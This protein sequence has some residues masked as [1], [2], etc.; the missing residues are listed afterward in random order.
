[1]KNLQSFEQFIGESSVNEAE[2]WSTKNIDKNT[3]YNFYASLDVAVTAMSD[4]MDE[5]NRGKM[6][7]ALSSLK[8]AYN[9]LSGLMKSK[10]LDKEFK[11]I[12]AELKEKNAIG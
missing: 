1:M 12:E 8:I 11:G 4:Y 5:A 6:D 3:F 7:K 9:E 2:S 10:A